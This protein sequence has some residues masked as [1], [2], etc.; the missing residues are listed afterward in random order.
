MSVHVIE[1]PLI[2]HKLGLMRSSKISTKHFRELASEITELLAYEATR[3]LSIELHR[4]IGWDGKPLNVERIN[5]K[6]ITIVPILR[7]GISMINGITKLIPSAHISV[8]GVYRN[9]KTFEAIPYF[10]KIV[11][12]LDERLA[13]I[14]DPMLATGGSIISVINMLK[15]KQCNKIKVIVLVAAPEGIKRV[16]EAHFDVQIYTA[17]IENK[18]NK[19]GYIV[20]GLGD[21]GDKIFGTR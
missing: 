21:A 12:A 6:N 17:S 1:H 2:K 4:I 7:A 15:E 20:P 9:K 19:Y 8:V 14:I 5:G 10:E 11:N 3:G 16:K 18:L 13:L